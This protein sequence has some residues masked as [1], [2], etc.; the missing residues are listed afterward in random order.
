MTKRT[1][2]KV[3]KFEEISFSCKVEKLELIK[4]YARKHD[5][6]FYCAV[7]IPAFSVPDF[8]KFLKQNDIYDDEFGKFIEDLMMIDFTKLEEKN[9]RK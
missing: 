2:E 5:I 6:P 4:E 1:V 3:E 8:E 9:D 7:N